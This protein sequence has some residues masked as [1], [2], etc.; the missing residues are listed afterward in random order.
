MLKMKFAKS[1]MILF[2][3]VGLSL[4]IY[5]VM[6][7]EL[8]KIDKFTQ[9][10]ALKVYLFHVD[11]CGHCQKYLKS[12]KFNSAFKYIKE[13]NPDLAGKVEFIAVNYDAEQEKDPSARK[14][15]I[16]KFEVTGFPAI[17]AEDSK[18]KVFKFT[19][20]RNSEKDLEKF[21]KECLAA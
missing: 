21:V 10:P 3:I 1:V 5:I 13:N 8:I 17:M 2:L 18:G 4:A 9:E 19:Y 6:N 14:V 7:K 15:N 12:D 20:D 16:N 11:W